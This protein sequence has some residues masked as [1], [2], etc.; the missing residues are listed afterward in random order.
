MDERWIL[1]YINLFRSWRSE[2]KHIQDVFTGFKSRTKLV[3]LNQRFKTILKYAQGRPYCTYYQS[4]LAENQ[5]RSGKV[6]VDYCCNA[7][8]VCG[9]L[10][11]CV[12]I[13]Y[14][15]GTIR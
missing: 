15:Y 11:H 8:E 3:N 14:T 2:G 4:L 10:V 12:K 6:F 5:S 7:I 1:C 9:I 13:D